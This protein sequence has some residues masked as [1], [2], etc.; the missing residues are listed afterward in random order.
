MRREPAPVR[1]RK[2]R[3]L[4]HFAR[5]GCERAAGKREAHDVEPEVRG[6]EARGLR[7]RR[8]LLVWCAR[9]RARRPLQLVHGREAKRD[10]R[11]ARLLARL[12]HGAVQQALAAVEVAAGQAPGAGVEARKRETYYSEGGPGERQNTGYTECNIGLTRGSQILRPQ[13]LR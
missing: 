9:R 11:D 4:R 3:R 8:D 13:T 1:A 5:V 12:A 10:A 2:P 6:A 7:A